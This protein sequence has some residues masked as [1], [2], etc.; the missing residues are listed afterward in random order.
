MFV[1]T[2]HIIIFTC[3][4]LIDRSN[5]PRFTGSLITQY[6][7]VF[8]MLGIH[9]FMN[10]NKNIKMGHDLHNINYNNNNNTTKR[11]V[12]KIFIYNILVY[13]TSNR[14]I[15]R[16]E[17]GE[18]HY[19]FCFILFL[20]NSDTRIVYLLSWIVLICLWCTIQRLNWRLNLSF[21]WNYLNFI[22][23]FDNA[24][25]IAKYLIGYLLISIIFPSYLGV[26][27]LWTAVRCFFICEAREYIL[28]TFSVYFFY[29][30]MWTIFL[31]FFFEYYLYNFT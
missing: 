26:R 27:C 7:L 14:I 16:I 25:T 3:Q 10:I 31:F 19:W 17:K 30:L 4:S 13:D 28:S 24:Y 21:S 2:Y 8:T 6:L 15:Y 22:F 29:I 9:F 12:K 18:V 20:I 11:A 5:G 23:F 1:I